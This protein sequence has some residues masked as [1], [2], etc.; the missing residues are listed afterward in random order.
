MPDTLA[1]VRTATS[2]VDGPPTAYRGTLRFGSADGWVYCLR[3]TDGRLF[4]ATRDARVV[5]FAK[6]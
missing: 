4:P 1:I 3:T 6:P 2:P 5:C